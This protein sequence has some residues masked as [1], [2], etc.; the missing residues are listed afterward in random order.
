MY[1]TSKRISMVRGTAVMLYV[2]VLPLHITDAEILD[3]TATQLVQ[4]GVPDVPIL[5]QS[6]LADICSYNSG[7]CCQ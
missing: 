6:V 2:T 5:Q 1:S 4:P 7:M 3:S